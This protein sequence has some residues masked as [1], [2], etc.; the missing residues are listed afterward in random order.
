MSEMFT[1]GEWKYEHDCVFAEG[2][3]LI[4]E[5][6]PL[7]A[8]YEANG[9]LLAASKDL[10]EALQAVAYQLDYLQGLWGKENVT[11]RVAEKV[12][13]ALAKAHGAKTT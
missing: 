2:E 1:P 10:H 6:F 12:K 8:E 13:A 3:G 5:V 4:C 7:R 11:D 9:R